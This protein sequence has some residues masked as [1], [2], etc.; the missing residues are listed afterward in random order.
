[1]LGS[2]RTQAIG[3]PVLAVLTALAAG[4]LVIAVSG[5]GALLAYPGLWQGSF[6]SLRSISETL[7]WAPPYIFGGLAV[8]LA[9][10]AGLF[11]IGA[12]GQIAAGALASVYVGYSL[13]GVP[14]P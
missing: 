7:V 5:G 3:L 8:A 9:F 2:A 4:A 12:E 10:K 6:G 14:W 13:H 1:M 11:N